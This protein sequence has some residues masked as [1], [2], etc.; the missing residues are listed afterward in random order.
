MVGLAPSAAFLEPF[1]ACVGLTSWPVC[2]KRGRGEMEP[3]M[4]MSHQAPHPPPPRERWRSIG[5]DEELEMVRRWQDGADRRARHELA[6]VFLPAVRLMAHRYRFYPIDHGDLVD[7]GCIGLLLALDRFEIGRGVRF[8][9][10][11]V[12]WVR[13]YMV[14]A[15]I[16]SW[17]RDKT[18][19]EVADTR[20]FFKIR[21]R[22][23]LLAALHD[24][25]HRIVSLLADETGVS[26]ARMERMLQGLGRHDWSVDAWAEKCG[27]RDPWGWLP[28]NSE[29][30]LE[31][32]EARE[33][34]E[35]FTRTVDEV[36]SCLDARER[37]VVRRRLMSDEP[38]TLAQLGR[39][40]GVSREW[41]RQLESRA[42]S[43][44][45]AGLERLGAL[46]LLHDEDRH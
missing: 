15:I 43:K 3:A 45:A 1:A 42:R 11:A 13:A 27:C 4:T 33:R 9:T 35:R 21:R 37:E 2:S 6:E 12:H 22:N 10:Y 5:R 16:R 31:A 25:R 34:Q 24:D 39:E 36:L 28:G 17:A 41:V 19:I 44:V 30:P 40:M 38:T 29:D 23:G 7:E 46:E 8:W 32:L 20:Y 18:G 26:E 14:F